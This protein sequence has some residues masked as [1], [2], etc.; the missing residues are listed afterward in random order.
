MYSIK[1]NKG[2]TAK[3]KSLSVDQDKNFIDL[4]TGKVLD[5]AS[6]VAETFG[7]GES[8]TAQI[9]TKNEEDITP[10]SAE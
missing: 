8:L 4:E 10:T 5:L 7:E 6:I 9:S 3:F 2:V 1:R